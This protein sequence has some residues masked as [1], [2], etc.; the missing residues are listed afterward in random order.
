MNVSP[1]PA[2]ATGGGTFTLFV[3]GVEVLWN[4]RE[5]RRNVGNLTTGPSSSGS[6]GGTIGG[7]SV[8]IVSISAG[9]DNALE[10]DQF[11]F[12]GQTRTIVQV[13]GASI[14]FTPSA[15]TAITPGNTLTLSRANTATGRRELQG[16]ISG[17]EAGGVLGAMPLGAEATQTL[18]RSAYNQELVGSPGQTA[19]FEIFRE[20][21]NALTQDFIRPINVSETGVDGEYVELDAPADDR[22]QQRITSVTNLDA[23]GSTIEGV[24]TAQIMGT[25]GTGEMISFPAIQLFSNP[26]GITAGQVQLALRGDFSALPDIQEVVNIA[27]TGVQFIDGGV[28]ATNPDYRK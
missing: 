2:P 8:G 5:A 28:I 7:Q 18:L 3:R 25:D 4:I 6:T 1:N 12:G 19:Y 24:I 11:D 13:N 15:G 10:G 22:T 16:L 26:A 21:I 9:I 27:S 14:N 23:D 20:N 17:T